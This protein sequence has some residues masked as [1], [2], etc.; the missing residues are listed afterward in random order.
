MC[1]TLLFWTSL[2]QYPINMKKNLIRQSKH[3]EDRQLQLPSRREGMPKGF[4]L[5]T[6]L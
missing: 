3:M 6:P 5:H 2:L 4:L 1:A